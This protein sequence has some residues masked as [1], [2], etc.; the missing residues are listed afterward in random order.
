MARQRSPWSAAA[1]PWLRNQFIAAESRQLDFWR[2][3]DTYH[4]PAYRQSAIAWMEEQNRDVPAASLWW[5][6]TNVLDFAVQTAETLPEWSPHEVVPD[7]NGL[8]LFKSPLMLAPWTGCPEGAYIR[9]PYGENHLPN[10]TVDGVWW[11]R[12]NGP[13]VVKALSRISEYRH[14][15]PARRRAAPF[16]SVFGVGLNGGVRTYNPTM[17]IANVDDFLEVLGTLM[18][19]IWLAMGQSRL[20]ES[21]ILSPDAATKPRDGRTVDAVTMVDIRSSTGASDPSVTG[22]QN[23]RSPEFSRRWWVTG[24]WRQ[25]ACGPKMADRKPIWVSPYIKGPDGTPLSADRVNV[26]R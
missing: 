25:Q 26:V 22:T 1:V 15:H 19:A 24:H 17:E 9:T 4:D 6:S 11:R 14:L 12:T 2:E 13:I 7:D 5:A 18:G 10:V 20:T 23:R 16:T 3:N 8:M 21:R